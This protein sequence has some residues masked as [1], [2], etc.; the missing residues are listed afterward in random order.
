MSQTKTIKFFISSTFK[1]FLKERNALQNFVFPKLKKLCEKKGF[2][3]QPVD[4]RWGVTDESS[5]DNQTMNFCLNEVQRCS[6]DP[7]PNLLILLGQRYGWGPLPSII[8]GEDYNN[9]IKEKLS[10]TL[11]QVAVGEWKKIDK[12]REEN[13]STQKYLSEFD[14]QEKELKNLELEQA[15]EKLS[16]KTI[17]ELFEKWYIEDFNAVPIHYYLKD[18]INVPSPLWACIETILKDNL[19]DITKENDKYIDFRRS[20]TELEIRDALEKQF[21]GDKKNTLV[22]LRKF[23]DT[24]DKD[25]YENNEEKQKKLAE[26]R[27]YLK[28]PNFEHIPKVDLSLSEYKGSFDDEKEYKKL[29]KDLKIFCIDIFKYYYKL[30]LEEMKNYTQKSELSIELEEQKEFLKSKSAVVIGRNTEVQNIKDFM[31]SKEQYYLLYGKSGSGKSAVIAQNISELKEGKYKVIY[32]FIGTTAHTSTPRDTYNHIY[33]E[34]F[35]EEEKLDKI[36]EVE[37]EDDKFYEQFRALLREKYSDKKLVIFIDAVDQFNSY[38]SLN[39]FLEGLPEN[40]KVV[41]ST[42]T[43][44][45]DKNDID[46]QFFNRLKSID[47]QEKLEVLKD[48]NE[49]ILDE[50]LK[51]VKQELTHERRKLPEQRKLTPEQRKFLLLKC[52]NQTPLYL[53]LAFIIAKEW[54]SSYRNYKEDIQGNEKDLILRFFKKLET[55]HYHKENLIANVLGLISASKDGLSESELIDL[56]SKEKDILQNYERKNSDY[57]RL[58][59]LPDAIFSRLYFH[60]QEF[61]TEKLIDGEM[62]INPFHRIIE[63]SILDE[64]YDKS[65]HIKLADYF[66]TLQDK[67]KTWDKRY[68]NIHMLSETPYQLFKAKDSERLK[69]LLFDLEFAG[70]I[71]NKQKQENYKIMLQKVSELEEVTQEEAESWNGFFIEKDYLI[72]KRDEEGWRPSQSLFQ[73]A[74]EDGANSVLTNVAEK[75][76][77]EG[78]VKFSWLKKRNRATEF[79]RT[80]LIKVLEGHTG[81]VKSVEILANGNILSYTKYIDNSLRLWNSIGITQSILEG[82][83]DSICGVRI[84]DDGRILSYS[85]D[86]TL[87][88][89][90]SDGNFQ[91]IMKGH[92]DSVKGVQILNNGKILS[93]SDDGTLRLWS[94]DGDFISVFNGH[95]DSVSGVSILEN[96]N[97]LSYSK[98]NTLRIWTSKGKLLSV[99]DGHTNSI[100]GVRILDDGR[101]LSYSKMEETLRIWNNQG[102]LLSILKGH[103]DVIWGVKILDDVRILSYSSWADT[104]LRI[105]S[106][107]GKILSILTGHTDWVWGVKIL[108]DGRILSYSKD[109]TLI[110]WSSDGNFQSI[111]KGHTDSVK[112]VQILNNGKILSYSDDGTLRLWSSDGDFISVFNGHS[113]SVSGVSILENGN[114]LSYSK[115]NTLRIWTS[116]GKLLSV[117]DGHTNSISGVRILDDGRILSYSDNGTLRIWNLI[118][119]VSPILMGHNNAISQVEILEDSRLLSY[120]KR[121]DTLR[122]WNNQ[123][124]LLSILKGH[125]DFIEGAKV[126]E[127]G[128][129]LSFSKDNTLRLWDLEGKLLSVFGENHFNWIKGSGIDDVKILNDGKILSLSFSTYKLW[130]SQG[131]LISVLEDL[132]PKGIEIF[133]DGKLLSY[134]AKD[135]LKLWSDKGRLLSILEGHTGPING[136][137]VLDD[138]RIL[139]YSK[140]NTLI[141]WNKDGEILS[142]LEGHTGPINGVKVLDDERILSYSKDNTLILW[143]KDGEILSVLE[144]H[145][146]PIN[147]VKILD[148]GRILSYSKDNTLILWNKDGEIVSILEGHNNTISDVDILEDKKILSYSDDGSLRLWDKDGKILSILNGSSNIVILND[149]RLLSYGRWNNIIKLWNSNGEYLSSLEGHT[150]PI[151]GV[152]ILEDGRILS[153]SEDGTLRFWSSQGINLGILNITVESIVFQKF[154]LDSFV[155][156]SGKSLLIYDYYNGTQKNSIDEIAK[157]LEY[158]PY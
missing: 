32:R 132:L 138:E 38:D 35:D 40:V 122:I 123:G 106:L 65:F 107:D 83:T 81:P 154:Y 19:L 133:K 52:E 149:K 150:G 94:S 146:G 155:A 1:D 145:T 34:L 22:Y 80:G 98:D 120:S 95:S 9:D 140:D 112:G 156:I 59:R 96:G 77:N 8:N 10:D 62:L 148:N 151:N 86:G 75:L 116:K 2:H 67:E 147:G 93:Y 4:L 12:T 127:D 11:L 31:N 63:E 79:K 58:S 36:P 60:M 115:D 89:W 13:S 15:F 44:H 131:E 47:K 54:K 130:S 7:K 5:E 46:T 141:L 74:F 50:W 85:D 102:K 110:L 66:L 61:F 16:K 3:F 21:T 33:W 37:H 68:N 49:E 28:N 17:Y 117:L 109:G 48:S 158:S 111:M 26:L 152:K 51:D 104:S 69:E 128:N 45:Q 24:S 121:E 118:E 114:I 57:P 25:Y 125:T 6:S 87:I 129:I 97:I 105:W 41:F 73:L 42:L 53:R 71:Y 108:I 142:I 78:H 91:S 101:I 30:I 82:H 43:E 27:E 135:T 55:D 124:K 157:K 143:N 134:S 64:F 113:D 76:L 139:S 70:S 100:S 29:A 92:T 126:L 84:F 136:V 137:K 103:T 23:K 18:K 153:F 144:G 119:V 88:L 39:I 20:A 72:M 14:E 90:S 56:L 99:L